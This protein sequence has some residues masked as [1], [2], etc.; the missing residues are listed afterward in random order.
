MKYFLFILFFIPCAAEAFETDDLL[1]PV[2]HG[3]GSY[4]ITHAM[5]VGCKK[6]TKLK[7][8]PCS[9][10]G[11]AVA[12]TVGIAVELTQEQPKKRLF[13]GLAEDGVGIG[14]AVGLINIDF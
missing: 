12:G 6:I 8:L 1:H 14:L 9:L 2:A 7:S 13:Q 5:T 10:F 4:L 3:A 11:A